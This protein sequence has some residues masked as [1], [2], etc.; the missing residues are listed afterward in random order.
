[1]AKRRRLKDETRY[2]RIQRLLTGGECGLLPFDL[3]CACPKRGGPTEPHPDHPGRVGLLTCQGCTYNGGLHFQ[4][5]VCT[6][7]NARQVAARWLA[8][9]IQRWEEQ[10]APQTQ[11]TLF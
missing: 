1:M 8:D 2:Q 4:N 5:R 7:A 3:S 11:P 9:A 6:H 10:Q